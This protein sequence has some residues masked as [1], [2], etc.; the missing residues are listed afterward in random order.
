[1]GWSMER[2]YEDDNVENCPFASVNRIVSGKW[3]MVIKDISPK[4]E[5]SL[6]ELG[7]AKVRQCI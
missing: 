2:E 3:T 1:M 6:T 5:Y 7:V 4:V